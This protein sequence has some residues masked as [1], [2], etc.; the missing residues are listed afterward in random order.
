MYI[1]LHVELSTTKWY[2]IGNIGGGGKAAQKK[3]KHTHTQPKIYG[4]DTAQTHTREPKKLLR[5]TQSWHAM[6][7][8]TCVVWG[9]CWCNFCEHLAFYQQRQFFSFR[10]GNGDTTN[11][12]LPVISLQLGWAV[13]PRDVLGWFISGSYK[14]QEWRI[15]LDY[16]RM[17]NGPLGWYS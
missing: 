3:R 2:L 11:I 9:R 10:V 15:T 12:L 16:C 17:N 8:E 7:F 1:T 13:E 14:I 5:M 4:H 6:F